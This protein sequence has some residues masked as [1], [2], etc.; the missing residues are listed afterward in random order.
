V[1]RVGTAGFEK[2]EGSCLVLVRALRLEVRPARP[3]DLRPFVP[4]NAEP[5][6][7]VKNRLQR[8]RPVA[9]SVSVVNAQ[10]EL[11]T[12]PLGEQPVERGGANAAYVEK[13]GRTGSETGADRHGYA[14]T[15]SACVFPPPAQVCRWLASHQCIL[16]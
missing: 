3:A 4:E 12:E 7:A 8:L 5:A 13:A 15:P 9:L 16:R 14:S 10:N 11:P 2:A 6:E 1:V